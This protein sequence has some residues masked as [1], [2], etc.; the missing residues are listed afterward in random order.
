MGIPGKRIFKDLIPQLQGRQVVICLDPDALHEADEMARA[1]S[2]RVIELTD[3]IDD[4]INA[5]VL[6]RDML[7]RLIRASRKVKA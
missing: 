6:D 5:G 2:G 3:K 4:V 7:R 1:V